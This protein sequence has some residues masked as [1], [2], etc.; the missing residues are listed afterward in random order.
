[1][2]VVSDWER[3]RKRISGSGK[4]VAHCMVEQDYAWIYRHLHDR[5][6]H[7]GGDMIVL[8]MS[9]S[10]AF[11]KKKKGSESPSELSS[12]LRRDET[13]QSSQNPQSS[14]R[15]RRG[16]RLMMS[17]CYIWVVPFLSHLSAREGGKE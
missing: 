4:Q 13:A 14:A 3:K 5:N 12:N 9:V 8:I 7:W 6:P 15:Q 2:G 11:G 16:T 10:V 17:F 1:M